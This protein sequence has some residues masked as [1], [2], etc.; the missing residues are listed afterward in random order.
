MDPLTTT[1]GQPYGPER[2][3]QIVQERYIISKNCNTSYKD[4]GD[5]TPTEREY[6]LSFIKEEFDKHKE[7]MKQRRG[8]KR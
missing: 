2:Y 3:K 6:I 7:M 4:V 5:M 8:R 1:D